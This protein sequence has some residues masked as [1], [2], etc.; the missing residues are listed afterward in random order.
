LPSYYREGVPRIL[1]EA[2]SMELPVITT[3]NVG[4]RDIIRHNYNGFL[5][6]KQDVNNLAYWMEQM[7]NTSPEKRQA[8][9]RRGRNLVLNVF[10]EELIVNRYLAVLERYAAVQ[11]AMRQDALI[12]VVQLEAK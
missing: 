1:L 3:D 2:A 6:K 5:C 10:R 4:C 11:P 7:L 9:G 8:M 12:P